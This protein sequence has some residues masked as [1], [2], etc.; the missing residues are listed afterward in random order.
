MQQHMTSGQK[1][2]TPPDVEARV[3]AFSS[4]REKECGS[5]LEEAG[6]TQRPTS[7]VKIL[8]IQF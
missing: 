2:S 6:E 5:S 8:F 3:L 7:T 4:I 1:V